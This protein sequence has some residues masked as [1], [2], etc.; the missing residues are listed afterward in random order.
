M[1]IMHVAV[2]DEAREFESQ[3][4]A[5]LRC[6]DE[7]LLANLSP[8]LSVHSGAGMVGVVAVAQ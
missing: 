5:S 1:A 6:P 8:G 3:L 7:I 4:R 2:P